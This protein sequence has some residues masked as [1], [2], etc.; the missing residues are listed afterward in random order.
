[1]ADYNRRFAKPLRHDF[2]VHLPL[3]NNENLEATF[4]WREH[5][6]VSKNLTLHYNKKL[7]LLEDN[8][9]NRRFQWKYIDV[10]Q[11]PDSAIELRANGTSLPFITY[12]RLGELYQ[13]PSSTTSAW[14]GLWR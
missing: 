14:D 1:M 13:G 3:E 5:R 9:E 8:E 10:W 11:Y 7:Y 6:K 12:D 4:T 2:D